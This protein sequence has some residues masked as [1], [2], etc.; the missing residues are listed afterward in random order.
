MHKLPAAAASGSRS[1]A[2]AFFKFFWFFESFYFLGA[3]DVVK[4]GHNVDSQI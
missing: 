3:E 1:G 4:C 2:P